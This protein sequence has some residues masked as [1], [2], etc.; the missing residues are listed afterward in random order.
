MKIFIL[1]A[2]IS[3]AFAEDIFSQNEF[4]PIDAS[5]IIPVSEFPGFW[6]GTEF[7]KAFY[8]PNPRAPR[9]V[10][11]T[12]APANSHPYQL[13]LHVTRLAGTGLCGGSILSATSVLT[14]AHCIGGTTTTLV[15]AGA[16]N[17][18]IVE[19]TQQ[20]R[21][22]LPEN[23]RVHP[24]FNPS[25]FNNNIAVLFGLQ[26]FDFNVNVQPTRL[27]TAFANELFVTEVATATGWGRTTVTGLESAVL[28]R[29]T[30]AVITNAA[31]SSIYGPSIV[32]ATVLC[33]ETLAGLGAQGACHG[34][35][36]G[37]LSVPRAGDTRPIQ[38]GVTSYY[39]AAGCVIGYPIGYTR[40][41]SFLTWLQANM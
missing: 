40:V 41:T 33:T 26:A 29:S 10:G 16:H 19:A 8:T 22:V 6:E 34:D 9:I 27:P 17:R 38:I 21:T 37:V 14:A 39:A 7:P 11:G 18:N 12:E 15:I 30:N 25:N 23:Y 28:R 36:G 5:S 13:A 31:C 3:C 35:D 1:V 2:I 20:R 32:P 24:L 4:L